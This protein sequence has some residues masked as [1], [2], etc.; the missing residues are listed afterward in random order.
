M[1]KEDDSMKSESVKGGDK[2]PEKSMAEA[3][4]T[5][6]KKT[7]TTAIII[8]AAVIV[9]LIVLVFAF[10][11]Y[12]SMQYSMMGVNSIG[13]GSH[14]TVNGPDGQVNINSQNADSWCPVGSTYSQSGAEGGMTM[15]VVGIE[16]SGKYQG[17]CHMR[18]EMTG[19]DSGTIDYYYDQEGAGYQVM[20]INGQKVETQWSKS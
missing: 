3:G 1:K 11:F 10:R 5:E 14:V 16:T 15:Q 9:L 2:K 4:K 18:Y 17:L 19:T 12:R 6:T 7:N 20:N 13:D 8:V